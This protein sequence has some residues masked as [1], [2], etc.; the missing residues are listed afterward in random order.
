MTCQAGNNEV[1]PKLRNVEGQ[2]SFGCDNEN[3]KG[4]A[5]AQVVDETD[6]HFLAS[7]LGQDIEPRLSLMYP[8]K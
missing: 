1:R 5:V 4:A 3:K 8:S 2:C 7:I 6:G